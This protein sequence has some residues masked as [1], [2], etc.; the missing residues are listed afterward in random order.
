MA[1]MRHLCKRFGKRFP[2]WVAELEELDSW[3]G[4]YR[5]YIGND[6]SGAVYVFETCEAFRTW[7]AYVV[8]DG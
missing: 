5:V 2:G 8:L 3:K 4:N 1:M 6:I 7:S